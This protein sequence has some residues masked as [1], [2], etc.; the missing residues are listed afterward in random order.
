MRIVFVGA[1]EVTVRTAQLMVERGHKVVIIEIDHAK[2]EELSEQLDCSFLHGD[3][4]KPDILREAGPEQTDILFCLTNNDQD[5]II[6]SLV[7]RSLG[8]HRI[9]TSI[10]DTDFEPICRELGLEATINPSRTIS[11][12]LADMA[13]G[14]DILELSTVIKGEARFFTFIAGEEHECTVAELE[15]PAQARVICYYREGRFTLADD[16]SKLRKDDEV[17]I[18]AHSEN[19][20]A[21]RQRF[22]PKIV[23][24]DTE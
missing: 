12:Y 22:K 10:R 23:S 18:L 17:V 16:T 14:S 2:I 6:A 7:G 13:T 1:S 4:S 24:K 15:L 20:P 11:R 5:N 3:G 21:L 19:L 8:F 9:V